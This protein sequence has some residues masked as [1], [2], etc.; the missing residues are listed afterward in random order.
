MSRNSARS[1]L[2]SLE[3]PLL[4]HTSFGNDERLFMK[5]DTAPSFRRDQAAPRVET[6]GWRVIGL[7]AFYATLS[8]LAAAL[9]AAIGT[10]PYW[11]WPG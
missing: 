11:L 10:L 9:S 4:L 1:R 8:A 5:R 7:C 3:A 2:Y 6:S